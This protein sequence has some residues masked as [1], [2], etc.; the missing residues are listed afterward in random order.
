MLRK[1]L[2]SIKMMRD[3]KD[4]VSAEEDLFDLWEHVCWRLDVCFLA[5]YQA[6]NM[7]MFIAWFMGALFY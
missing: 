1:M 6:L 3:I 5:I 7:L 2:V 4:K